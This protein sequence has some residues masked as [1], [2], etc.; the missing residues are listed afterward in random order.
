MEVVL[1]EKGQLVIPADIRR[2]FGL[3]KG[4]RILI[5]VEEAAIRLL[6]RTSVVDLCGSWDLDTSDVREMLRKDRAGWR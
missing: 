4:S 1:S 6:P 3:K 2:R 5:E